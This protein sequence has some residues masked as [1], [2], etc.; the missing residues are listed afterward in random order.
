MEIIKGT[1]TWK[2]LVVLA[3]SVVFLLIS[4]QAMADGYCYPYAGAGEYREGCLVGFN[5]VYDGPGG[6]PGIGYWWEPTAPPPGEKDSYCWGHCV[7]YTWSALPGTWSGTYT[8]HSPDYGD[9]PYTATCYIAPDRPPEIKEGEEFTVRAGSYFIVGATAVDPDGD[10][11]INFEYSGYPEWMSLYGFKWLDGIADPCSDYKSYQI[12]VTAKNYPC[13]NGDFGFREGSGSLT[14]TVVP[15]DPPFPQNL[16]ALEVTQVVQDLN[17]SVPLVEDKETYV[18]AFIQGPCDNDKNGM[19]IAARLH[20]FDDQGNTLDPPS[21]TALN[22][23]PFAYYGAH[24][25]PLEKRL[26][27]DAPL[28]F[29]LPPKW[30]SGKVKLLLERTD[31]GVLPGELR[32]RGNTK[33]EEINGIRGCST[34]VTFEPVPKLDVKFVRVEVIDAPG[35]Y[36]DAPDLNEVKIYERRLLDIFPVSSIVESKPLKIRALLSPFA[37]NDSALLIVNLKVKRILDGCHSSAGCNRIYHGLTHVPLQ[38]NGKDTAGGAIRGG[39]VSWSEWKAPDETSRYNHAHELS[40]N[41]GKWHA[42]SESEFGTELVEL[43][44]GKE[45]VLM[46]KGRCNSY[47]DYELD[48]FPFFY[49]VDSDGK[50]EP[51]IGPMDKGDYPVIFGLNKY[52]SDGPSFADQPKIV[53]PKEHFALMSYCSGPLP[54]EPWKWI[55]AVTYEDVATGIMERFAPMSISA[56]AFAAS[57]YLLVP[58]MI[59][60]EVGTAE[61]QPFRLI[62]SDVRPDMP[63]YG[64]FLLELFDES[65]N[66]IGTIPFEPTKILG[67]RP[68]EAPM[69]GT[70]VI[71]VP[72]DPSIKKIEVVYVGTTGP[73]TLASRSQSSNAPSV[74]VLY[75]NGGENL[76]ED[77]VVVRWTGSD[78][79]GD[80]LVYDVFYSFN[81]GATWETFAVGLTE[82][83]YEI[84]TNLLEGTTTGLFKVQVSDGFLTSSD[85]SDA[86]FSVPNHPPQVY[87]LSPAENSMYVADQLVFL[88]ADVDDIEDVSLS[89]SNI[90]WNSDVD[91]SLGTGETLVFKATNL[92]EG[93]HLITATAT[94]SG[95]LGA[96][97]S[98]RIRVFRE[99][100]SIAAD[101]ALTKSGP[102][103]PVLVEDQVSYTLTV[104]NN[105]PDDA[106]GVT[107]TDP[108]P[109]QVAFVSAASTQGDCTET[110]GTVECNLGALAKDSTATVT[111]NVTASAEGTAINTANVIGS[112]TDP[113]L[114]NN[115][116]THETVVNS[117]LNKAPVAICLDVTVDAGSECAAQASIDNGSF[118]PDGDPI[119]LDQSPPGPYPL[120]STEVTLTVTDD[121]GLSNQCTATVTVEDLEPPTVSVTVPDED[122]ALQDGVT[123]RADASDPCAMSE[124][125]FYVREPNGASGIPIGYE[126]L[127]ATFNET[128]GKW[129]YNFDTTQVDDGYYV[130]LAKA[131]D[132]NGNEGWSDP[133]PLSI[134]N[135]AVLECLPAC[136]NPKAGRM[137][138]VKF[139]LRIVPGVDPEEPFVYNEDLE[140]RIY[141]L[142]TGDDPAVCTCGDKSTD[143]RIDTVGEHYITNYKT[144][145]RPARY[146]VEIWRPN[147][148]DFKVGEF[149]FE[150]TK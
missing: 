130:L 17:N 150:T 100:P 126:D 74:Q 79:D 1:S 61:L 2:N 93:E 6:H 52:T 25:N 60:L 46:K 19:P 88:E 50:K 16:L 138:P 81:G 120:D 75:P 41:L 98:V 20:G 69:V 54:E 9:F 95:G 65:D 137:M 86:F 146:R 115:D 43:M 96:S 90:L 141:N 132:K 59:D 31:R 15:P 123:F 77:T 71:P 143:Y 122:D 87:I 66:L 84:D 119:T 103:D 148:N 51:T 11:V 97:A 28:N 76:S 12:A 111:L 63:P 110:A 99:F 35:V 4:T 147:N 14:V 83:S 109:A 113:L 91:G 33:L 140:I 89:G 49:D 18:R 78:L 124:L 30:L 23:D 85:V 62:S 44:G 101:L 106:T 45:K 27:W 125:Y 7:R 82:T 107:V 47:A 129:E 10:S 36:Y 102:W 64:D 127:E 70:F 5:F 105:G 118:D 114:A 39:N 73:E 32:C 133:V 42:V 56:A 121:S 8:L 40:H 112:E 144:E 108:L 117:T 145:K 58:G 26:D 67:D 3:L 37:K 38:H 21:L 13:Q 24:T 80:D 22:P 48:D 34:T 92:T 53:D 116:A 55:S 72:S 57:D 29:R 142:L 128:S 136:E 131:V 68:A 139:A 104:T 94:D 134:R 135:W 149:F